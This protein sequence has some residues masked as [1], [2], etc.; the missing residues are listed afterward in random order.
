MH[1]RR[2]WHVLPPT[3]AAL[4]AF[5]GS[6]CAADPSLE[7]GDAATETSTTGDDT[8]TS[9]PAVG[10]TDG[11]E[12]STGGRSETTAS[13]DDTTAAD[14]EDT[15]DSG[16]F[17]PEMD[18]G[19]F[20]A[21]V[22]FGV[23]DIGHL[24][25]VYASATPTMPECNP[26]PAPCGGDV[27]GTWTIDSHCGFE[28][29]SNFFAA[30]CPSSTMTFVASALTGTQTLG[31][32]G[33]FSLDGDLTLDLDLQIDT[34]TCYGVGCGQFGDLLTM[35]DNNIEAACVDEQDSAD[36]DCAMT[37]TN[38]LEREGSFEV[39][40]DMITLTTE[41]GTADPAP[42]CVSGEH[43]TIWEVLNETQPYPEVGCDAPEDCQEILGDAH[44]E[45]FC[46]Q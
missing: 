8:G 28:S 25:T 2:D 27:V 30:E 17:I 20:P 4:V 23:S 18:L 42:Y 15:E 16:G 32:D 37:I 34:N 19:D 41:A 46:L 39:E 21:G 44:D 11:G 26:E 5:L 31:E 35:Q 6:G 40:G 12:S 9:T 24:S 43:L 3:T 22:C 38:T 33:S 10:S 13:V 45:W 36:C 1:V 7:D 29:L 14:T